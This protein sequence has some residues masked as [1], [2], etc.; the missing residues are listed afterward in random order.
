MEDNFAI[1]LF[2]GKKVRIVWDETQEKYYFSIVDIVQVLTDSVDAKQYI[3]RLRTRDPELN[4]KWGTICT[5]VEMRAFD[6]KR[7]MVQ[8]ADLQGIFRIIQSIP[9]KKAA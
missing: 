7:R 9:S 2:E 8:A 5:P 4:I 6:G 3:K 1:Q